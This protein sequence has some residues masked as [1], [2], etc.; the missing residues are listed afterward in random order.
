MSDDHTPK[1]KIKPFSS[2][3]GGKNSTPG[4]NKPSAK[5]K[6]HNARHQIY[7]TDDQFKKAMDLINEDMN[8]ALQLGNIAN[9]QHYFLVNF[10]IQKGLINGEEFSLF[11]QEEL[12]KLNAK[13]NKE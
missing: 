10:L 5:D 6:T 7:V 9:T 3:P 2:L 11:M 8:N 1:D 13:G 4:K 12:K